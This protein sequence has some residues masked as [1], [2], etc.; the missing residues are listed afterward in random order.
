M[1]FPELWTR[2]Q[3]KKKCI[4]TNNV[5]TLNIIWKIE[6]YL[7]ITTSYNIKGTTEYI[8]MLTKINNT[9]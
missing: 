5:L 8:Y 3:K 2:I 9:Y 6:V 1:N 7:H 4:T